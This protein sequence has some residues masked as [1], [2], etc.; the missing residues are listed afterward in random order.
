MAEEENSKLSQLDLTPGVAKLIGLFS[1]KISSEAKTNQ[2]ANNS[3]F[4]TSLWDLKISF[5]Q[6]HA[7]ANEVD[8]HTAITMPWFQ[9]KLLSYFLRLN[10]FFHETSQGPLRL[11]PG[12]LPK[13]PQPPT[14]EQIEANPAVK[15]IYEYYQKIHTETF[16]E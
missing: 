15:A 10:L 8:W 2:Y 9:A 16:G 7:D 12:L 6:Y 1:Q 11:P 13:P 5:G 4:D 3:R 14:E